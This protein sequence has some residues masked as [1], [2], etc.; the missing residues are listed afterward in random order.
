M[1]KFTLVMLIL[2]GLLAYDAHAYLPRAATSDIDI[3]IYGLYTTNDPTCQTGLVA[4]IPMSRTP[5]LVDFAMSPS[6][7]RGPVAN[8]VKCMIV[9][10]GSHLQATWKSGSYSATSTPGMCDASGQST[11]NGPYFPCKDNGCDAGGTTAD[12]SSPG[13]EICGH[14][15]HSVGADQKSGDGDCSPITW[16]SQVKADMDAV[17]LGA[18]AFCGVNTQI[19]PFY[20]S[21][22]S[23]CTLNAVADQSDP[24]CTS[25]TNAFAPPGSAGDHTNGMKLVS[26][27]SSSARYVLYFD[28]A[29][30]I[31]ACSSSDDACPS[32]YSA[33]APSCS[34]Q[35]APVFGF[36]GARD[37]E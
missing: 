25:T 21:V 34:L 12:I 24:L 19:I 6:F 18:D 14:C 10:A 9:V 1:N 22:N 31:G 26:A 3:N 33:Q 8:P 27:V 2:L 28:T 20:V 5:Q 7:G 30:T 17:G 13:S 16:P 29:N 35:A 15:D 37:G 32:H 11:V 23:A 36:R 4:T